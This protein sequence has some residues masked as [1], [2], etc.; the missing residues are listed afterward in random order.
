MN[1][2]GFSTPLVTQS[3]RWDVQS[4]IHYHYAAVRMV[5]GRI[6]KHNISIQFPKIFK[7][8]CALSSCDIKNK[9]KNNAKFH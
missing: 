2:N 7:Q 6:S 8:N 1:R 5:Q 4:T 9:L 3:V